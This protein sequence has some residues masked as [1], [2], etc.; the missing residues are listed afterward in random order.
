M[1]YLKVILQSLMVL[2]L[3]SCSGKP[4]EEDLPAVV[5]RLELEYQEKNIDYTINEFPV[6][7]Q[8]NCEWDVRCGEDWIDISPKESPHTGSDIL[9][10]RAQNNVSTEPRT[11]EM[12]FYYGEDLT[13]LKINQEAF[14]VYLSASEENI[15]FGYRSVEKKI[16]IN[17]NCGWFAK[18]DRDWIVIKP[19]TGLIGTFDMTIKVESNVSD[20]ART[21]QVL[22][23]NET[24]DVEVFINI[25]QDSGTSAN[26][27][28]YIDEY[29][30]DLG[31]GIAAA[32]LVWAPVNCGWHEKDYPYG[33]MYQWGRKN[34][35][36]YDDDSFQDASENT[37]ADIWGGENGNESPETFYRSDDESRYGYDW[38]MEGDD[39][40]W[41]LGTEENPIKNDDFDPCP[42]GWR[43]PTAYEYKRLIEECLTEWTGIQGING[44]S[45][46]DEE[47]SETLLFLP[48]GGR[49]NI[50]DGLCYDRNVEGYY[51]SITTAE[52]GSSSYLYFHKENSNVNNLGSRAGAC[53]V[54]CIKE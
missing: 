17:S 42:D 18:A 38:I 23:W 21:G 7:V 16:K 19:S 53:L 33:K 48:A 45:F 40:F 27:K 37:I 35:L 46:K 10:I 11:A 24:Y 43:I 8:A 44:R 30:N 3:V 13:S 28:S 49:I 4:Y 39:T 25:S 31:Q 32:G 12:I 51:W 47:A 41:N 29:G 6:R 1:E 26:D 22:I 20:K 54:R 2:S 50:S 36:G 14:D 34:G 9:H 5:D 52:A 15:T